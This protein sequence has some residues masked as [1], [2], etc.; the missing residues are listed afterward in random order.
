MCSYYLMVKRIPSCHAHRSRVFLN[1]HACMYSVC[2]HT[3][4]HNTHVNTHVYK[5]DTL[6]TYVNACIW[7]LKVT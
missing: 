3:H 7:C 6:S 5:K 1:S 4:T 2:M